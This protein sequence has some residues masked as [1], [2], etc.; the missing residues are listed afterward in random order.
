MTGGGPDNATTMVGLLIFDNAF[1]YF[2]FG[3]AAAQSLILTVI[4]AGI[5]LIQF[6]FLGNDVEY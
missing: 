3:E 2:E 5:S 4:I 6:K 1:K